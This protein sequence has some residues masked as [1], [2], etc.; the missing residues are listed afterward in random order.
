MHQRGLPPRTAAITSSHYFRHLT[1]PHHH[2]HHRHEHTTP[3]YTQMPGLSAT[4]SQL[5]VSSIRF[6]ISHYNTQV[7]PLR[8]PAY[9]KPQA[10]PPI[11]NA[12]RAS[13]HSLHRATIPSSI[14]RATP[15]THCALPHC[16]PVPAVATPTPLRP[17]LVAVARGPPPP[18]PAL[19][20][21][22]AGAPA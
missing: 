15:K 8:A 10:N 7:P 9:M 6:L 20:A 19:V 11:P 2:R 18:A 22:A 17:L 1:Q 13:D 3:I 21:V 16:P 4:V 14:S 12:T 5:S